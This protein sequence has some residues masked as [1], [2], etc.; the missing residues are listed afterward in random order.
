V[1]RSFKI[2]SLS[3]LFYFFFI[4][5]GNEEESFGGYECRA[6]Y[7]NDCATGFECSMATSYV[8]T[9]GE[10]VGVCVYANSSTDDRVFSDGDYI[11][12]DI[13]I[14]D[15]GQDQ[16]SESTSSDGD[17]PAGNKEGDDSMAE[18]EP[19]KD[20]AE[21]DED[22][23]SSDLI[24]PKLLS[25]TPKGDNPPAPISGKVSFTFDEPVF[26]G[27]ISIRMFE[28]AN[29]VFLGDQNATDD[30]TSF[31]Y[32][33]NDLKFDTLYTVKIAAGIR[34][35]SLLNNTT[36]EEISWSFRT[37]GDSDD[38]PP[39]LTSR[40]PE[41]NS[42]PTS[43]TVVVAFNEPVV[44]ETVLAVVGNSSLLQI[45]AEQNDT[46]FTFSYSDLDGDREYNAVILAGVR[47]KSGN[48]NETLH[49]IAWSFKTVSDYSCVASACVSSDNHKI[50]FLSTY[51]SK[52]NVSTFNGTIATLNVNVD[53]DCMTR[54]DVTVILGSPAGTKYYLHYMDVG[55]PDYNKPDISLRYM[56]VVEWAGESAKG[57][58]TLEVS[59]YEVMK[60]TLEDWSIQFVPQ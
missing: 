4:S 2:L 15:N 14:P 29:E 8:N 42:A 56:G 37:A 51:T 52:I 46:K 22:T 16:S 39:V 40:T 57:D 23:G 7:V 11:A 30:D 19:D 48:Q 13:S 38:I 44:P 55:D 21:V 41:G 53:I 5:C 3:L 36:K 25:R 50:S 33:Y 6:G 24:P 58:W 34:D 12:G 54:G 49:N 28:G 10:T 17:N 27:S 45:S 43:G 59:N 35:K 20:A 9:Q 60:I 1:G 18:S 32:L 31:S 26:P 47:D